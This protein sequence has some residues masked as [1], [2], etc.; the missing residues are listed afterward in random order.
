MTLTREEIEASVK[1]V[2]FWRHS[3]DLGSGVITPGAQSHEFL[4]A[5]LRSLQLPATARPF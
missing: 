3:I 4:K 1:L 2:P 5:R